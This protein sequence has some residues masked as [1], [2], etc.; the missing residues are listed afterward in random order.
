VGD[1]FHGQVGSTGQGRLPARSAQHEREDEQAYVVDQVSLQEL[2]DQREAA[3]G[4][5]VLVTGSLQVAYGRNGVIRAQRRAG[6]ADRSEGPREHSGRGG[7]HAVP[8]FV[9]GLVG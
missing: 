9:A 5:Q 8:S 3:D 1:E 4:A 2:P 6:P 7:D